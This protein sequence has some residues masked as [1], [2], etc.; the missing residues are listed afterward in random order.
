MK[1]KWKKTAVFAMLLAMA[2]A[3][4]A[5]GKKESGDDLK[6]KKPT[7]AAEQDDDK[8]KTP[9]KAAGEETP[10]PTKPADT[11]GDKS[12]AD[13]NTD[14]KKESRLFGYM[15]GERYINEYMGL[16][17]KAAEP[18]KFATAE[19]L[20]ELPGSVEKLYAGTDLGEAISEV[21]YFFDMQAENAEE[22]KSMNIN[23]RKLPVQE[24]M[25]YS[26][27][28]TEEI[29]DT[30]LAQKDAMIASYKASGINVQEMYKKTVEFCGQDCVAMCM[31]AEISGIPYYTLQVFHYDLGEY[32]ATLTLSSYY[33]NKTEEMVQM[34][35]K[36][37]R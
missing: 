36:N 37:A 21:E 35:S 3:V 19:E 28:T 10:A 13:S 25:V 2:F 16:T 33:E 31:D 26:N 14:T 6:D 11:D 23:Y 27:M 15:D 24:R 22:M 5:C 1:K 32:A 8:D 30:V 4:A 9:T 29:I 17:C 7:K 12:G 20:Q 18:W 34:F